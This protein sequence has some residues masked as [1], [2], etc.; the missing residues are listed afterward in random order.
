MIISPW[1]RSDV[2]DGAFRQ[3]LRDT[4]RRGVH[5]WIGYG[6]NREGGYRRGPKGDAD[7]DTE[8]A[9]KLLADDFANFHLNRLGDTHAKVLICD[10]R[11]SII[12][13]FNW[14]SFRGDVELEFRDERGYYVGLRDR[15]DD[16]FDSYRARFD[17]Q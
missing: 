8:R 15:V 17:G 4:L 9:L 6:I 13:S 16:L 1:V 3:Q 5:V 11:F 7:R 2:V 10:S 12:T 14:L